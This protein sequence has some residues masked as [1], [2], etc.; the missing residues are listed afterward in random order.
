MKNMLPLKQLLVL[1]MMLA[2]IGLSYAAKP[3]T[4]VADEAPKVDLEAIVPKAFADWRTDTTIPMILPNPELLAKVER[5]YSQ[6]LSRTYVNAKGERI[7]LSI[8][9]GAEQNE[10]LQTHVP[11]VCYP[12]Q[13]FTLISSNLSLMASRF[14]AF[15]VK[16]LVAQQGNRVEPITYWL[17]VGDEVT[18]TGM[19]WKMAQLKY[20]L[21]GKIP[22]GMLVRVSNISRDSASSYKLHDAFINEMLL[23]LQEDSRKRFVGRLATGDAKS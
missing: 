18:R 4:R 17:T 9:Y 15:D 19:R 6:T 3:R 8:A 21:T 10:G 14:G 22:D 23:A 1:I 13:G 2:A 11:E 16:R 20:G 7:M 5:I 12:A